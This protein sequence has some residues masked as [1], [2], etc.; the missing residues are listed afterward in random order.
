MDGTGDEGGRERGDELIAVRKHPPQSMAALA[1][2][3]ALVAAGCGGSSSAK[4]PN[5]RVAKVESCLKGDGA[6]VSIVK[7]GGPPIGPPNPGQTADLEVT[8]DGKLTFVT[9]YNTATNAAKSAHPTQGIPRVG[10]NVVVDTREMG[11][12]DIAKI[13]ACINKA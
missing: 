3:A 6:D 2:I 13:E 9:F 7:P 5:Y 4:P 8:I 12:S 11:A 10:G 1:S